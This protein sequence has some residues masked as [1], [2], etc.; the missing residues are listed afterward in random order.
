MDIVAAILLFGA[1][2]SGFMA[3]VHLSMGMQI[4]RILRLSHAVM[5]AAGIVALLFYALFT[6]NHEKHI[7]VL[8]MLGVAVI[9]GLFLLIGKSG[10]LKGKGLAVVYGITGLFALLWLLTYLIPQ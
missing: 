4:G 3:F 1:A 6:N 2:V 9:P 7:N 10:N 5:V 8:V